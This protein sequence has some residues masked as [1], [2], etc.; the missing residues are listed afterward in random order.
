MKKNH[1]L[2]ESRCSSDVDAAATFA[3]AAGREALE[4]KRC[5]R[6]EGGKQQE[7]QQLKAWLGAVQ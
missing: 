6:W 1:K 2:E 4:E 5:C 7:L 3:A